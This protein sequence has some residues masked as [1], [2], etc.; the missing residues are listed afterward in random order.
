ML[1]SVVS[2]LILLDEYRECCIWIDTF[3]M[4]TESVVSVLILTW[5]MHEANSVIILVSSYALVLIIS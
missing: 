2:E 5:W 3:L 1:K 4:N